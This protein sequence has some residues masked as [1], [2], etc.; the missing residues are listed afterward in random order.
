MTSSGS[1]DG[2]E[3][4]DFD[5]F[6]R[7]VS[8]VAVFR[9]NGQMIAISEVRARQ[10]LMRWMMSHVRCS[11]RDPRGRHVSPR[12][13]LLDSGRTVSLFSRRLGTTVKFVVFALVL[14]L[15]RQTEDM[16]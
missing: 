15:C 3:T 6:T 16:V 9:S 2:F 7:T 8:I 1:A 14:C 13:R 11:T 5:A 4:Y 12:C 10:I